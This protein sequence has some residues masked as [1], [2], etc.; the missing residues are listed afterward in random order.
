MSSEALADERE[1]AGAWI[2]PENE[3]TSYWRL[4]YGERVGMSEGWGAIEKIDLYEEPGPY[5]PIVMV[6]VWRDGEVFVRV[7]L[8]VCAIQ[9][10]RR[11][12]ET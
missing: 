1:I 10:R 9:Y 5:S 12:R 8:M 4:G 3:G 2:V 11:R 7:P 6:R